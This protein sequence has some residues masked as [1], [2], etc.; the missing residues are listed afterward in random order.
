MTC[1]L[2]KRNHFQIIEMSS[3][4]HLAQFIKTQNKTWYLVD[5]VD[6]YCYNW[7][8]TMFYSNETAFYLTSKLLKT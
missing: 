4:S 7:D 3:N 8:K 5:N 6:N 1:I 2:S